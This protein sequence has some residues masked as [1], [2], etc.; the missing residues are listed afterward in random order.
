MALFGSVAAIHYSRIGLTLTHYDARAHLVVARRILDSLT[1]GWQ[2]IGAVW[3][4]LP[5]V[6]NMLPVQIDALYR[7]GASG[8]AISILAMALGAGSLASLLLRT[9]GSLLAAVTGAALL[10]LNPNVLYLQSTPMTEPL[11]F[12]LSLL[13]I[14]ATASWVDSFD[15]TLG[16][17]NS[18]S[19][20]A[21]AQLPTS[22]SQSSTFTA[23]AVAS[24]PNRE[25]Q[26]PNAALPGLALA[27]ACMTRYEAW[28]VTGAVLVLA[29]IVLLR[30]GTAL[31][32]ALTTVATLAAWPFVAVVIFSLNSRW[33]VGEW[34]T[35]GGFFVPENVEAMGHPVVAWRQIMEGL[36]QL[37]GSALLW[38]GY[39]GAALLLVCVV[40]DRTRASLAMLLALAAAAALPMY[41]Y[42]HGHPFRVRYDLPLVAAA[43]AVFAG[44][45]GVLP[46][47]LR[48]PV[49]LL[50]VSL[51][52]AQAHPFDRDAPLIRESQR[53]AAAMEGRRAVTA[54]LRQH[55]DGRTI[56]MSMGSLG[57]YMHDLSLAG[58]AIKD[59][60]HEG[61][62]EIWRFAMLDPTGHAGWLIV[63]ENAEGG[64]ALHHA[65]AR[66]RRWLAAFKKV[67][68][69]GG[70][71][72][73]RGR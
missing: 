25:F 55:Y 60:L 71:T 21:N 38:C 72:L 16:I 26:T 50:A 2:Q 44:G 53:E 56:M 58:F 70:A 65:A 37:S 47:L 11:L 22:N 69:G 61:N 30:R 63:E 35:T 42:L 19:Q 68:Q 10:M 64:D 17:P 39:I 7:T 14:A 23:A 57:H 46:R 5:H 9:T 6:L 67:A 52:V 31:R 49:A 33:V 15:S 43:A 18:K 32:R 45:V 8:V 29:F 3:L 28:G 48:A 12:G 40:R 41:A 1:P 20:T 73:Y 54:Y 24:T 27:A 36:T 51:T 66:D 4:P 62:G 34:F 59:F 13:A